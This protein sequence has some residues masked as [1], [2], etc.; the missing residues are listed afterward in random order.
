MNSTKQFSVKSILAV[1]LVSSCWSVFGQS[2]LNKPT[3]ALF[4]GIKIQQSFSELAVLFKESEVFHIP[5]QKLTEYV[6]SNEFDHTLHLRL[7]DSHNWALQLFPNDLRSADYLAWSVTEKGHV[8]APKTANTTFIGVSQ[9]N[10]RVSLSIDDHFIYG[11]VGEN[12]KEVFIEPLNRFVKDTPKDYFV[13]Y[14]ASMVIP[15]PHLKCGVSDMRKSK[16][17]EEPNLT[18]NQTTAACRKLRLAIASDFS[19]FQKQDN[20]ASAARNYT[21]GVI[22]NVQ[23][24][25]FTGVFNFNN[26]AN[27]N[28]QFEVVENVVFESANLDFTTSTSSRIVLG[29]FATW[30]NAANGFQR[31]FGLG[32]FWTNRNFDGDTVG[33]ARYRNEGTICSESNKYHILQDYTVDAARIQVMTAHEIG[34]TFGAAH[35]ADNEP[36]FVMQSSVAPTATSFSTVS[37]SPINTNV[38]N[39]NCLLD[40]SVLFRPDLTIS[41]LIRSTTVVKVGTSFDLTVKVKNI[42]SEHALP[43]KLNIYLSSD[44]QLSSDD[45]LLTIKDVNRILTNQTETLVIP[46][47]V[48]TTTLSSGYLIAKADAS[49]VLDE[50]DETNNS[51]SSGETTFYWLTLSPNSLSYTS[52]QSSKTVSITSNVGA[53]TVSDD[54]DW[55]SISPTSGSNNGSI[56]ISCTANTGAAR[57][58]IVTVTGGSGTSGITQYLYVTQ[59]VLPVINVSPTALNATVT[60]GIGAIAVASNVYCTIVSDNPWL[61]T[62]VN[63]GSNNFGFNITIANNLLTTTR[64]GTVRVYNGAT[65]KTITVTQAAT[66]IILNVT[67]NALTASAT[68]GIGGIAVSSNVL[69]TIVSDNPWLTASVNGGSNNFGFNITVANNPLTT[70]RTGTVRVYNGAT[71]KTITVTQAA[72]PVILNV[73]PTALTATA[74]GGIGSIT[75]SSNVWCTIV[76]D[77]PWLTTSVSSGSNNFGFSI[78]VANNLLTSTRTGTVRVYNGAISKTITITQAAAPITINVSPTAFSATAAG[79][80]GGV[81][82]TS[83]V[84][85]NVISDNSWLTASVNSGSNNFGFNITVANNLLT[86]TRTGTV[87]V[88]N[89]AISKTITITQAAAPIT[90]NVSPTAFSATAAG[91]TGG[92]AV[93]SNV[94]CNVISDNSWLT[95]STNSGSNNFGFNISVAANGSTVART[96]TIRVYNG[97]VSQTITVS[98]AGK[99]ITCGVPTGLVASSIAGTT[100]RLSWNSVSGASYYTLWYWNGSAWVQFGNN[101]S[102]TTIAISG[103]ARNSQYYFAVQAVCSGVGSNLSS[104]VGVKT[105]NGLSPDRMADNAEN[106]NNRTG[107]NSLNY[108]TINEIYGNTAGISIELQPNPVL[109]MAATQIICTSESNQI[110][111]LKISD[112]SGKELQQR[113]I[114]L[115]TGVNVLTITAPAHVGVYIITLHDAV[116]NTIT[117]KMVVID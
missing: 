43:S 110:V 67:P 29:S 22:N 68:G 86:S 31:A 92:V 46:I 45:V 97:N 81:A 15:N 87:R 116:G 71:S 25:F 79:G 6:R 24:R 90:I 5:S 14:K 27:A 1:L 21:L 37:L 114:D 85:C 33:L 103:L 117:Q 7:G 58:A 75:V 51:K 8:I 50:S 63:G 70:I 64:T 105:T 74:T 16:L 99:A 84:T 66:P 41:S 69:C 91:G 111:Q 3:N 93:T 35:D 57:T 62:S 89:G 20:N 65:S 48:N 53:W 73:S 102:G 100:C 2:K 101:V 77:N 55:V 34:H 11:F 26:S 113:N 19:M 112:L 106:I 61:T 94:T 10:D 78:T 108:A 28:I 96:G 95:T 72:A 49:A 56:I 12:Q 39:L 42:G 109:K 107:V 9:S 52:A 38:P 44:A 4:E 13:V 83:N 60:G 115:T 30:A 104:Y 76:S 47:T 88:Y 40:C 80:T 36:G 59:N 98:Q 18:P 32:E 54:A 82:V 17:A 23:S